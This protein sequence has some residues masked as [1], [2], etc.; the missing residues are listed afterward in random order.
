MEPDTNG[1]VSGPAVES[2]LITNAH[3]NGVKVLVSVGG[4]AVPSSTFS[5]IMN[6]PTARNNLIN[7]IYNFCATYGYDGADIDWEY[8]QNSTDR[9]NLN[10]FITDLRAKFN[11]SP[12][13][14]PTW[15]IT[16][17][18]PGGSW[19]CQYI[20][21]S[22]L[23]SYVDFYNV[24]TYDMHG[25]WS[26]HSGHNSAIYRGSDPCTSAN[27][28]AY[29][30]YII[31]TR[32]VPSQKVNMGM[33]FY[34][35]EF[36]TTENLY[37]SCGG[38]CP[39]NYTAYSTIASLVGNGWTYYWD[40]ASLVPY[41]RKDSGAGVMSYDNPASIEQKVYYA[42]IT[43]SA[44]GVFMWEITQ[45][46]ISGTQPL[47]N[48]MYNAYINVC[49]ATPTFTMTVTGTPPTNTPTPVPT[50]IRV[51]C[52][53]S[54]YTG[55]DSRVWLA[56]KAYAAG[57]WGYVGGQVGTD[58]TPGDVLNTVD[59]TLYYTERYD[60]PTYRFDVQNGVWTVILYFSEF[61][62]TNT[63]E[64]VFSVNIEGTP[65]LT[66]YDII[67]DAGGQDRAV[68]KQFTV[69]ITDGRIDI[70]SSATVDLAKFSA[71]EIIPGSPNTPTPTQTATFTATSTRTFTTTQ[72]RTNTV[73]ATNTP[74]ATSTASNTHSFTSTD[75][76]TDTATPTE[77]VTGSQPPTWTNTDTPTFTMT[78]TAT[79]TQTFTHTETVTNTATFT[80]TNTFTFIV[81]DTA[82]FTATHTFTQTPTF[83]L[84]HTK[85]FTP[86][87]SPT[88]SVTV[89]IKTCGVRVVAYYVDWDYNYRSN[90]IPYEKLTH[91]NHAFIWP[92]PDASIGYGS[93]YLEPQL[94]T[95]AHNKGVKVLT[96]IGTG[97]FSSVVANATLRATLINNI[98]NFIRTNG[99][100]G[101]DIDWEGPQNATDR[102]NLSLFVQEL[103]QKFNTSP[104]P[105]PS[106][107]IT[108]AVGGTDNWGQWYDY[109]SLN[110]YINFFNLMTYDMHGSWNS[111]AAHNSPLFRGS[112]PYD[113]LSC[114]SFVN[115]LTL[116]RGIPAS[117]INMGIPFY[118][119][120][121]KN[122]SNLYSYCNG[123]C[124][125]ESPLYNEIYPLIGNGWTYNWDSAS[126]V[127]YLTYDSG[128]GVISYDNEISVAEKINYALNTRNLGGVF[129]W[130]L[131]ADYLTGT[132]TQPLFN[133][134][135]NA[136][137]NKCL[138]ITP[139]PTPTKTPSLWEITPTPT[140]ALSF[141][142]EKITI[143]P[144][145]VFANN[146]L[147]VKFNLNKKAKLFTL[148]LYTQSFRLVR[149]ISQKVNLQQG[150]NTVILGAK[151]FNDL[152]RGM[153]F[154]VVFVDDEFE[155]QIKSKAMIMIRQ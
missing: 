148:K 73:T 65:V 99:Y 51:N 147:K 49:G 66:N 63:G 29:M 120:K 136:C 10:T 92:Q 61:Y 143:Y 149:E 122:A 102:S 124:Q 72:T 3:S 105:A 91:I 67:A 15:L 135:F 30:N 46:Y 42:L 137:Y 14:A 62:Y 41:L 70:T 25:S 131:S 12:Q 7:N 133:S 97:S 132:Q 39:A 116:S 144:N 138:G 142:D 87:F 109:A 6:N 84:T 103:R 96:C 74:S 118:G 40:S 1:N 18:V 53:G 8:P 125:T 88:Q 98:E 86:T 130:H 104:S 113:N 60:N 139:S 22:Y 117:K 89:D 78:F 126:F 85:T 114:E 94:I 75:T 27:C 151:Y 5:T 31:N 16:M 20:D 19:G 64:R 44:G 140:V 101:I 80:A 59:D 150:E 36:T 145:P 119:L 110:N 13:P 79:N 17:A 154:Y 4:A 121:F 128:D 95:N 82:T 107:L 71:I 23:N 21:F 56:D 83:T 35:Y 153:Y 81:T 55:A 50:P 134:M 57:S 146:D 106:W 155:N 129:M 52:G 48:A 28:E 77:T 76:P 2:G 69:N 37:D 24:M 43:R 47:M 123:S 111:Y 26:D 38:N 58:T 32:G 9:T 112:N 33:P 11:S 152:A 100:D 115:Y 108:M 127:P 141:A 93:G 54:Q 45:D 34:G 90:K 68:A